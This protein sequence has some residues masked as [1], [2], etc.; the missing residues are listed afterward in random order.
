MNCYRIKKLCQI[1][2]AKIFILYSVT[3]IDFVFFV[4]FLHSAFLY[5]CNTGLPAFIPVPYL[6]F[7]HVFHYFST[8]KNPSFV[9][10]FS[11]K[12]YLSVNF[13]ETQF[14]CSYNLKSLVLHLYHLLTAAFHTSFGLL[15]HLSC[16]TCIVSRTQ[17]QHDHK[18]SM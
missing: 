4:V 16:C 3:Q 15:A 5:V 7:C 1:R 11:K 6:P 8:N 13:I 2:L 10:R 17:S 9:L 14:C 18:H 12:P